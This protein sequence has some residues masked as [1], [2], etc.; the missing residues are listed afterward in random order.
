MKSTA[1]Y[2]NVNTEKLSVI[3]LGKL[4]L[5]TAVCLADSEYSV[6][7]IDNNSH[8]ITS[9]S[10]GVSPHAETDLQELLTKVKGQLS[11]QLS[12]YHAAI[13]ET[14]VTLLIVPTPSMDNGEFSTKY[15]VESLK[16]M[17]IALSE[18]RKPYHLFV[19]VSTVSPG[20]L[21]EELIPLVE[22]HSSRQINNGFGMCYNPEFIA[23]GSVIHDFFNPDM[24]LIGEHQPS[25]GEM[26]E[27]IYRNVCKNQP[28]I[29]RMSITSA[30]IT[31]ISLNAFVTMKI[32]FANTLTSLCNGIPD[33]DI[34]K[35]TDALGADKRI[36]SN[37]L[38]GGTPFGGPCFPRDNHAFSE[39]A[40]RHGVQAFLAEATDQINNAHTA[41][42]V[43]KVDE[44]IHDESKTIG[45]LGCAYKPGT[46]VLEESFSIELIRKLI[47]KKYPVTVYD[48]LAMDM[49]REIFG[50]SINYSKTA[51]SCVDES[52]V[53]ILT[54]PDPV[55]LK[56]GTYL[57]KT[58]GKI[59]ID[60]WRILKDK[61]LSEH[62]Y[63]AL[64]N[65]I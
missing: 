58:S 20:T 2:P 9:I 15:L 53:I 63:Y 24:V 5:C 17:A 23:L 35:I 51:K 3:G 44:I 31:K 62:K 52:D 65:Y 47:E 8:V 28:K 57:K 55:Y 29:S 18:S 59:I 39:F 21:L 40:R 37:F 60:L 36:G 49:V 6:L 19:I 41:F 1:R 45:V 33:T 50:N 12:D 11:V 46:P 22:F 54:L 43:D 26:L 7:G 13:S 27:D 32:S 48:P 14:D 4:G 64:G 42:I 56:I 16:P 30:E 61:D 38:R 25:D 34:D 10:N